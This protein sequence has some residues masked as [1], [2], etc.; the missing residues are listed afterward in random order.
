MH[1]PPRCVGR[2]RDRA[3]SAPR[4]RVTIASMMVLQKYAS[5]II[6]ICLILFVAAA[7]IVRTSRPQRGQPVYV[8]KQKP[9]KHKKGKHKH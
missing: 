2:R 5:L 6:A 8:E 4:N 1:A 9:I 3:A 7:C